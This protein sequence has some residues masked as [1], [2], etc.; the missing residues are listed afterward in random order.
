MIVFIWGSGIK[1]C[2]MD[3]VNKY[4]K[5]VPTTTGSGSMAWPMERAD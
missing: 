5:T 4:G 1:D 2:V 3:V